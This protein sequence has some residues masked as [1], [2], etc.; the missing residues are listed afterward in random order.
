MTEEDCRALIRL[1][2]DDNPIIA[3]E[4]A[5]LLVAAGIVALPVIGELADTDPI[6][7]ADL[8]QRIRA[9]MLEAEWRTL[10]RRPEAEAAALLLAR[11]LDPL[12]EPDHVVAQL[13][14]L[15]EP[16][17]GV[18]PSQA[19]YLHYR[20][21]ALVLREWLGRR[22]N[23]RGNAANYYAPEN[24]LL[25]V[26]LDKRRG[27]PLT[28]SMIYLFVARRL[29][30]PLVPI[31]MPRHVIVRY[32]DEANGVFIDPFNQGALMTVEDCQR[33]LAHEGIAWQNEFLTPLSDHE[34]IERMLRNLIKAYSTIGN[35]PALA[36]SNKYLQYLDGVARSVIGLAA[37]DCAPSVN[38]IG[39]PGFVL[40][41]TRAESLPPMQRLC[42]ALTLS[43]RWCCRLMS[44]RM[45]RPAW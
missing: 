23:F 44:T 16:L 21:D 30:A 17:G 40:A 22:Q 19:A 5:R 2:Q 18:V 9:Q 1:L 43:R 15:A 24:S 6:L 7:A 28:L 8:T 34:L 31:A 13:D 37:A 27:L 36:Q 38:P 41:L 29:G 12:C 10:A 11:W 14:K 20:N 35:E 45:R 32:G 25:S 4:A 26:V 3:A 39:S 33:F 42:L